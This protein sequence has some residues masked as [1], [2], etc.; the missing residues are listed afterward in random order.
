VVPGARVS[1]AGAALTINDPSVNAITCLLH[2][3]LTL[4]FDRASEVD[5]GLVGSV[6]RCAS[7]K[8][9]LEKKRAHC[10]QFFAAMERM[11]RCA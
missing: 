1:R 2:D 10:Q 4:A 8:Y 6:R 9:A 3:E 11:L 5:D 7:A